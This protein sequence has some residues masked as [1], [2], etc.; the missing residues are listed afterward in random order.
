VPLYVFAIVD[1]PLEARTILGRKVATLRLV[2]GIYAVCERRAAPP[3]PSDEE[4]RQQHAIVVELGSEAEAI[5]PARFGALLSTADLRAAVRRHEQDVRGAL[6][7]VKGRVQMTVRII[8]RRRPRVVT[9]RSGREYLEQR[10][11]AARPP[12][13]RSA[14][15]FADAV[16]PFV[17]LERREAGA[18]RLLA[19]LYHL[20]E[21]S[22]I[23]AYMRTAAGLRSTGV[24][25]SGPWPPFAFAP[26]LV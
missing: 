26:R 22:D 7:T 18:G 20:V 19:T 14:V 17:A 24:L 2:P 8:G 1:A 25:V 16:R 4:L 5:L 12:L 9:P 13:P 10:R 6:A 23:T 21:R 11:L 3:P 15:R